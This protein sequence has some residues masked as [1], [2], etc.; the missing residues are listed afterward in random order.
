MRAMQMTPAFRF[1]D[2]HKSN[3]MAHTSLHAGALRATGWWAM[4]ALLSA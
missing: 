4:T 3:W 1:Q 2:N